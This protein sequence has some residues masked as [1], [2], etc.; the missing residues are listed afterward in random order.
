M[1]HVVLANAH[2]V[3][4]DDARAVMDAKIFIEKMTRDN[5]EL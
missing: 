4:E 1:L 5:V 3:V 2:L